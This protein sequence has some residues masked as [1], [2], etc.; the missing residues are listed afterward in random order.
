MLYWYYGDPSYMLFMLVS[1]L[2]T[3]YAQIKVKSVFSK[4]SSVSSQRGM[5]GRD[6]AAEVLNYNNVSGVSVNQT[7][8]YLSD[9]YDSRT[10]SVYLSDEVYS[11]SSIAAVS[12][13]AHEC[14]H[15]TQDS[16]DYKP[17]RIRQF[18]VPIT[19]ISSRLSMPLVFIGLLLPTRYQFMV[20]LGIILFSVAVLFQLI[21]LPV[22]F[23]ASRRALK[24]LEASGILA[25]EEVAG[26]K[27]VLSAAALT[28]LAAT[29]IALLSLL[30][31]IFLS[32]SRRD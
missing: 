10:K 9:Y 3:L 12:V 21:T 24:S 1:I 13:A 31:L 25:P 29:F 26:A 17:L 2:V 23:D 16:N 4:Y 11:K 18:L 28:Y 6:V 30:R 32:R 20:D 19:N 14:G 15:A 27:K 22:E 5:A 8:G 7:S